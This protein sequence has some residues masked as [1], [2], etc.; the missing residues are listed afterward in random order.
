MEQNIRV[1]FVVFIAVLL[2]SSCTQKRT[3]AESEPVPYTII[4]NKLTMEI[5]P[6]ITVADSFRYSGAEIVYS[7]KGQIKRQLFAGQNGEFLSVTIFKADSDFIRKAVPYSKESSWEYRIKEVTGPKWIRVVGNKTPCCVNLL[8]SE[9]FFI[10]DNTL[11]WDKDSLL[12][13]ENVFGRVVLISFG[14]PIPE[15][16]SPNSWATEPDE[17][18][19]TGATFNNP[20]LTYEVIESGLLIPNLSADKQAFLQEKEARA[21]QVYQVE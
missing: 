7:N 10:P 16:L 17:D 18:F 9:Y 21:R 3:D 8:R 11:V 19:L 12:P 15:H 14:T 5:G 20:S 2:F 6:L 13:E 4:M 1:F